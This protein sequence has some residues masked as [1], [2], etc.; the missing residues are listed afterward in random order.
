[1]VGRSDRRCTL[2]G[3]VALLA[4]LGAGCSSTVEVRP[5]AHAVAPTIDTVVGLPIS[6]GWGG[7]I[8]LRKLQRR[9]SDALIESTGGRAVIAE[10]LV[11]GEDEAAV[12]AA[13]RA[14]GEDPA[15]ALTFALTVAMGG[16]MV[17]GTSAIPGFLVGKRVVVD[18][19]ARIEVRHVGSKQVLGSVETVASGRPNEAEVGAKGQKGAALEAIGEA[20]EKALA[21]FAPR[22]L[23]QG[24]AF[25]IV[26]IPASQ[27]AS[28]TRRLAL[29]GSV[30]PELTFEQMQ[31]IAQSRER[32]FVVEP[33]ELAALGVAAGDMLG[34]PGGQTAASRAALARALSRGLQPALAVE[35]AGQQYIL[36]ATAA[37]GSPAPTTSAVARR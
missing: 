10:E 11:D 16:R 33:G 36:A 8:D 24:R 17:A 29:L 3:P 9:T 25:Q 26:E 35:R 28:V 20:V 7:D 6:I 14:L 30:Y 5:A 37:I 31:E 23:P 13:L 2:A 18:Y 27:A 1:M 32:F 34:V 12:T 15:R 19:H 22:L 4:L 21:A